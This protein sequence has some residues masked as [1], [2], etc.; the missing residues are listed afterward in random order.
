MSAAALLVAT[1]RPGARRVPP[2]AWGTVPAPAMLALVD[3]ERGAQWLLRRLGAGSGEP[4][5]PRELVEG[6]RRRSRDELARCL[7]VDEETADLVG[8]LDAGQVPHVLLKGAARRAAAAQYPCADARLT[9]DVDVLVPAADLD[10]A[11]QGL[12]RRGYRRISDA[13]SPHHAPPLIG[14]RRVAVEL[15]TSMAH[16]L[17][18]DEA[19][20]RAGHGA[21]TT[22][23]RGRD[24]VVPSATELLWHG[25]A[26][27]LLHGTAAFRLR[28]LIDGVSILA[29]DQ[30]L[31]WDRVADRLA[32]GEAGD[33]IPARRWLGAAAALAD[34]EVPRA[35]LGGVAPFPLEQALAWRLF[36]LDGFARQPRIAEGLI[37]EGTR[38][39][40]GLPPRGPV[41][42]TGPGIRLRRLAAARAAR[43]AFLGWRAVAMLA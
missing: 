36:V 42:G 29:G 28:Y 3:H 11:W 32:A 17:P 38:A 10:R 34:R 13:V 19:W 21:I 1:L 30:P 4:S 15:H 9:R 41:A 5:A 23:W 22:R 27:A 14:P 16:H 33:A 26:H 43:L 25:L 6:L 20:R 40:L 12:V 7:L 24:V 31:D 39:G 18:A 35:V 8:W 2:G 37:E